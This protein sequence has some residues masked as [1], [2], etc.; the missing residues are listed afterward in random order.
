MVSA[1][2]IFSPCNPGKHL[3]HAF[4]RNR[5]HN[6]QV[7]LHPTIWIWLFDFHSQS[8][9]LPYFSRRRK[10]QDCSLDRDCA[11]NASALVSRKSRWLAV[12]LPVCDDLATLDVSAAGW[13]WSAKSICNR[14]FAFHC[15]S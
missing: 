2:L 4:Q 14:D 15:F 6:S 12:L 11:I 5:R 1:W 10:I 9:P 7:S 3:S 13:Q 8:L